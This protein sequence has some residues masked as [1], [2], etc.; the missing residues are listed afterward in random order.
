MTICARYELIKSKLAKYDESLNGMAAS[1]ISGGIA[2]IIS[3]TICFPL[4]LIMRNLQTG[5]AASGPFTVN[6]H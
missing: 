5:A 6:H 4:D 1:L 3:T 2:G